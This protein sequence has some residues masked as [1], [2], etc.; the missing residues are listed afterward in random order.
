MPSQFVNGP[1]HAYDYEA[2]TVSTTAVALTATKVRA[3]DATST[4]RTEA[5]EVLITVETQAVRFRIDGSNPTA[6]EGH[7]LQPGDSLTIY[8]LT[9][10]DRFR[11]IRKDAA[12]GT[13]RVTYYR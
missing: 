1:L 8:G 3:F 11:A 2:I 13:V 12:D 7:V 10:I 6:T 5:K 4:L 9:N